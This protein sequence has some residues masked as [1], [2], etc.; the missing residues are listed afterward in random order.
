MADVVLDL[1][2]ARR[3][4]NAERLYEATCLELHLTAMRDK[5]DV[6][7]SL[8][9]Q[10]F[11]VAEVRD[12]EIIVDGLYEQLALRQAAVASLRDA[13]RDG[14]VERALESF[15]AELPRQL[16]TLEA[17]A[18]S[19][20]HKAALREYLR[21]GAPGETSRGTALRRIDDAACCTAWMSAFLEQLASELEGVFAA[22]ASR[23][24]YR[25]LD[26]GTVVTALARELEAYR[27]AR[28][29]VALLAY[30][31]RDVPLTSMLT[32]ASLLESDTGRWFARARASALEAAMRTGLTAYAANV[33]R[34]LCTPRAVR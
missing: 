34:V 32:Y 26:S 8:S 1:A 31:Y 30:A 3:N 11:G 24:V 18:A 4:R 10:L 13:A 28:P 29:G 12:L 23:G 7:R 2:E 6:L 16:L 20:D 17:A 33:T 9:G 14:P 21:T 27:A 25:D 5:V 22:L 19:P 15:A